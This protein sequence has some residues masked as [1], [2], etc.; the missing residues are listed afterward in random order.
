MNRLFTSY[1]V[2]HHSVTP[3]GDTQKKAMQRILSAHQANGLAYDGKIAYHFVI[4]KN[5]VAVGRPVNSVGYHAGNWQKNLTSVAICL[6]GNFTI[7][8][9]NDYQRKEL[10]SLI[11]S[12]LTQYRLGKDRV[13]RHGEIKA[14]ACPGISRAYLNSLLASSFSD[15]EIKRYFKQ[16]WGK[17]PATGD[18]TYFKVRLEKGTISGKADLL[19]KMAF[20]REMAKKK[21]RD[22][23]EEKDKVL[24]SYK[25]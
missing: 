12:L 15:D 19:D 11:N 22:W 1:V 6:V 10:R 16:V 18:W 7:D 2:V 8:T 9:L 5:W 23:Q 20:Y 14:T 24:A 21:D 17:E 25:K 4:G 3:Q 13:L